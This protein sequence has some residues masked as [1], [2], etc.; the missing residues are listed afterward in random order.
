MGLNPESNTCKNIKRNVVQTVYRRN[1]QQ[2]ASSSMFRRANTPVVLRERTAPGSSPHNGCGRREN[3]QAQFL[4]LPRG[5]KGT[6]SDCVQESA[7]LF[8]PLVDRHPRRG[9]ME[10]YW[11]LNQSF[12]TE[13]IQGLPCKVEASRLLLFE[14]GG[15]SRFLGVFLNYREADPF[16]APP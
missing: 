5:N 10:N 3:F 13:R 11:Q 4:N 8:V 9:V 6:V 2:S 16:S 1:K 7:I 12:C 14:L 15:S